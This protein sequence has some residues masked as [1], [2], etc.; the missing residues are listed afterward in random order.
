[1][2]SSSSSHYLKHIESVAYVLAG[3]SF[4]VLFLESIIS[5]YVSYRS[6]E[7]VTALAN[8]LLLSLTILNNLFAPDKSSNNKVVVLDV[9]ML[10]LGTV[11]FFYQ[12]KFVIF[13][14]LIRQ[15]WFIVQY[16]LFRAF[17]G[18]LYQALTNNPPVSL[19][20]SFALL[21]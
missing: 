7:I 14:L 13:F 15:T 20:I 4:L 17:E 16:L 10:A 11:L 12:V 21:S 1:M 3:W 8:I 5:H 18:R 2:P 6:L 9:A 19:M